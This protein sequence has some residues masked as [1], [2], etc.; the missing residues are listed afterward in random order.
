MSRWFETYG[1]ADVHTG[2]VIGAYPLDQHDVDVLAAEHIDRILNLV[3]DEEYAPGQ[4]AVI[5]TALAAA[6]IEESRQSLVDFG[7]LAS[8]DIDEAVRSILEWLDAGHRVYLHCRAGWQ[9]S[10]A[11]AAGVVAIREHVGIDAALERVQERKPDAVPL[12][13]QREDL[14]WWWDE[15]GF[16][17]RG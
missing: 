11:I 9:R 2:L 14:E 12:S 4:R 1:F 6:G 17:L 10:A 3:E 8:V 7:G 5:E 13:H 16:E 15:G